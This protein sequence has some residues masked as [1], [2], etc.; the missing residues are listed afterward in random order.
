MYQTAR[1]FKTFCTKTR[2]EESTGN[3]F[4]VLLYKQYQRTGDGI[5]G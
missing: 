3:P 5:E 2:S 1:A 4:I